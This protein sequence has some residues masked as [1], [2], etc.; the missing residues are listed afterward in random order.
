MQIVDLVHELVD[1]TTHLRIVALLRKMKEALP[2]R[3]LQLL[4]G[5][6]TT[7]QKNAIQPYW[8]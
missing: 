1:E 6:L 4:L 5:T 7:K 2:A 3:A 8:S